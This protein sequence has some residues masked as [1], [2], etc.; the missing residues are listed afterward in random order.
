MSDLTVGTLR[1]VFESTGVQEL[2]AQITSTR[3]QMQSLGTAGADASSK[4]ETGQ[5]KA[6]QATEQVGKA[7]EDATKKQAKAA[8]DA[9]QQQSTLTSSILKNKDA[10]GAVSNAFLG[11]GAV[12]V[13]AI[14]GIVHSTMGFD[15][16]MSTV[17]SDTHASAGTMSEFR[18]AAIKAGADTAYSA[19]EAA[20]AI[21]EMA[22][23]GVSSKDILGGGL[24][25]A[26]NLA[27]AGG[28][29]V[30]EAAETA[31]TSLSTFGL[32]GS[33]VN[34]VADL[35]AAGAGK[36]QGSVHDLGAA[37]NQSALVAKNT[38][39]SID[40]TVG[41]LAMFANQGLI[42][43]DAGT[44]FKT[45][46]QALNP[47]SKQAADLVKKLGISAYDSQGN[48]VGLSAYAQRLKDGLSKLSPE[49]RNAALQTIFGSDAVRAATILYENGSAGVDKWRKAVDD[50]GY[51]AETARAKQ[52][53]L[54]GDVEKLG[55]SFDSTFIKSGS[56]VNGFFRDVVQGATGLVD[57]LGS[58][59]ESTL[60]AGA[61]IIGIGSAAALTVGGLM[62]GTVAVAEFAEKVKTLREADG[63][64][65]SISR[66]GTTAGGV[67]GGITLAVGA[68]A[69]AEYGAIKLNNAIENGGVSIATLSKRM[70]DGTNA[71]KNFTTA[72]TTG[73]GNNA[74]VF[75]DAGSNVG[76]LIDQLS[77]AK[78]IRDA[79]NEFAAASGGAS[80]LDAS[81]TK[82]NVA[83]DKWGKAMSKTFGSDTAAAQ[84][85]MRQLVTQQGLSNQQVDELINSSGK[86]KS[87]LEEAAKSAGI[88]TSAENLRKIA[89]G[90]SKEYLE[91]A[92]RA[93]N[94][95]NKTQLDGASQELQWQQSLNDLDDAVKNNEHSLDEHTTA[96]NQNRQ[97]LAQA[98]DQTLKYAQSQSEAGRS[99]ADVKATLDSGR[100]SII[101]HAEALGASADEANAL[102]DQYMSLDSM[103]DIL[104]NVKINGISEADDALNNLGMSVKTLPNGKIEVKGDNKDAMKAIASVVGAKIDKK[105]GTITADDQQWQMI[106]ALVQGAKIDP[107]TGVMYGNNSDY[108]KQWADANGLKI[109][110]KTGAILGDNGPLTASVNDANNKKVF[111]KWGNIFGNS[112]PYESAV[113]AALAYADKMM[114]G[115]TYT[116]NGRVNVVAG[117]PGQMQ[118]NGGV[119][120]FYANGGENHVAQIA[121]AGAW[122]VF[123]EP[124]TGGEAYIPLSPAKR[125]RS[126]AILQEVAARF[127]TMV[128]PMPH[129]YADGGMNTTMRTIT[130]PQATTTTTAPGN[131]KIFN[132][133]YHAEVPQGINSEAELFRASRLAMVE[134]TA[135]L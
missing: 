14:A 69:L 50:S 88:S 59:D 45:M 55:G 123:A 117:N 70:Q 92:S 89:L 75:K 79:T 34:H 95:Y 7:A 108:W 84:S 103:N 118:A 73:L 113:N 76:T 1:A 80:E 121:P 47:Q 13:A 17:Q 130:A 135:R 105:T 100:Q 9:K 104:K 8:D 91:A 81:M 96:G 126:M 51:A 62:K 35:L 46:L 31:A 78:K 18:S 36:A 24:T 57:K 11:I 107:K 3:A 32:Q 5:K 53:N 4:T 12:G 90:Q 23:A 112:S 33:Q 99:A 44:S 111:D 56:G 2:Q 20:D 97:M 106:Y 72:F 10:I 94:G 132:L 109:D 64:V 116:I 114:T 39:L 120:D 93:Q 82:A 16:A 134:A 52:N 115:R 6:A 74:S 19:S 37:M 27:A 26:L 43:S 40:D 61:S 133:H 129:L 21:D 67:V 63:I 22:K 68:M 125:T 119:M 101:Q 66:I 29:S 127:G 25:G 28:L 102:A 15:K 85:Q 30:S 83:V 86:Y 41:A 42:G 122:R 58:V 128:M 110:P 131:T 71:T 65:G 48:F 49:A 124:E 38:G 54:A 77:Q 98:A 60:K 87:T